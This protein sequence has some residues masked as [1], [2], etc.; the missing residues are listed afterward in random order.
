MRRVVC[1]PGFSDLLFLEGAICLG[2]EG[3][4]IFMLYVLYVIDDFIFD[5]IEG[6]DIGFRIQMLLTNK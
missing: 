5:Q 6:I 2:S 1:D 4:A 3:D